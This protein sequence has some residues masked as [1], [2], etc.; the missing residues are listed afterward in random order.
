[1]SP[2]PHWLTRL[3]NVFRLGRLDRELDEEMR[4][5]VDMRASEYEKAGLRP[6]DATREALKRFGSPLL[7]RERVRDVRLFTWLDSVRQDVWLG[8]RRL[9]RSP[10]L[11][12]AALLSLGLGI[13]ATTGVFAV[14]DALVFRPLPVQRPGE[15]VVAQWRSTQWPDI[16][17]WGTNDADGNTFSFSYPTWQRLAATP[18][19]DLAGV[20][21]LNGGVLSVRG[22]ASNADG[23]V[24]TGNLF[25]VLGLAPAAGRLLV[26]ADNVPSSAPVI[27]ISHRLWQ[28]AF[29]GDPGAIG[30]P[31]RLNGQLFT[32]AGVAPRD[33][34][35]TLPGRWADFYVPACWLAVLRPEFSRESPLAGEKFWWLQ[36]IGR[37]H[38][39]TI[40]PALQAA[41]A[42]RFDASVRP[43]ITDAKQ[44]A[45]FSLRSGK[46][47]YA[48]EE[49]ESHAPIAILM[50][51]VVLVLLVACSNVAN[52]LLARDAA[53]S[54]ESAMRLALGAG[55]W[56]LVRQHLTESLVLSAL[57]GAAGLVFAG[58]FAQAI[59]AMAPGR[60]A[61][62][63][64]LGLSWRV[65]GFAAVLTAATGLLVG[66][67]PAIALSRASVSQALRAGAGVRAGWKRHRFGLGRPLV[68]VQIALSLVVLVV[69]GLFVRTLGNLQSVPLG[70]NPD[71]VLLFTLDP[72]AAG[73]SPA[74]KAAAT[75]RIA[76]RLRQSPHVR[77]V[78][79]SSF[80]LLDGT[81]WNTLVRTPDDPKPK[82]APC[83]LLWIEPG[84]HR[85]LQIPLAGG[86]LF[87]ERDGPGAP[88]VA[89]VNES[90]VAKYL[91]GQPPLGRTF[92]M[93]ME[94]QWVSVEIVGVVRDG[95]YARIRRPVSPVAYFPEAQHALPDGPTFALKVAG[96]PSTV[97]DEVA[98][99]VHDLEPALPVSRIRTFEQQIGQQ[100]AVERSLSLVASAFG[101][102]ALLLASVGLYGVIAF[103]V[104]RRTGEMGVRLALG[105]SRRAVLTLVMADSAKV[106]VPGACVGL[107]AALG[108]ARLV[109]SQLYGLTPTDP[110]TIS[111]AVVLLA[112]VAAVAAFLP[113]RRAA[114]ID[115]VDALRC[116]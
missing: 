22:N 35:G 108:A 33:F 44:N 64:D 50:S 60:S 62:V 59:L 104:A 63:V 51:L 4:F 87:E 16:G 74:Q 41:M 34:F 28:R 53:R 103:A 15:L 110:A 26:E 40:V 49:S 23:A 95:K 3:A 57:G 75:E 96:D 80:A 93:E 106:I 13:G 10:A 39:G 100:L 109:G 97:S 98:K 91:G 71:N 92:A 29:G 11:A 94:R 42:A 67:A 20:Q 69:A 30:S 14:G 107:A 7:A 12:A 114:A 61:R 55:R 58:W 113:A 84:F 19:I 101:V 18:G 32:V 25:R 17:I 116:E 85:L 79:W 37:P 70:L 111:A 82:P 68:A 77:A 89:I 86:R 45:V 21:D 90:F 105:A 52:L 8:V 76:A 54:R 99:V 78:T 112:V 65:V 102:V 66:F 9:R 81:S 115:P 47:G 48:F 31:M 6:E 38:P 1:M 27:V 56:R 36:L 83:N 24:V 2:F 5:H 46:Q 73:Y 72:T 43:L 88:K